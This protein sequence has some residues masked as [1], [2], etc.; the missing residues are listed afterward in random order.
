MAG[1]K[2]FSFSSPEKTPT[3]FTLEQFHQF[4]LRFH[5]HF[6]IYNQYVIINHIEDNFFGSNSSPLV[7][8]ALPHSYPYIHS[9]QLFS[10][11]ANNTIVG[12]ITIVI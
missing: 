5:L 10:F 9:E 6:N 11:H 7:G 1:K 8:P 3:Y 12:P 2:S 4:R